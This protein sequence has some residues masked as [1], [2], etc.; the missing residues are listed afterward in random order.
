[1]VQD[2]LFWLMHEAHAAQRKAMVD[3]FGDEPRVTVTQFLLL[4]CLDAR[5]NLTGAKLALLCR[6][7]KQGAHRG[8]VQLEEAGFIERD[9]A[10]M[11]DR[12]L[13]H[14]VTS[15]GRSVLHHEWRKIQDLQAE[16]TRNID[17]EEQ[18]LFADLLRR[19]ARG[20]EGFSRRLAIGPWPL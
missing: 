16:L 13:V 6:L 17:E 10:H 15:E 8:I 20:G 5:P 1:M 4:A 3:A 14:R 12:A 2:Q 11:D 19:Y 18:I 7:T 9:Q